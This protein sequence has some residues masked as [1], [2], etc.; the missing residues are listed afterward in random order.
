MRLSRKYGLPPGSLFHFMWRAINGERFLETCAI[1]KVF[2]DRIFRFFGVTDGG[3]QV[4]S[5]VM[6]SNHFHQAGRILDDHGP[7]SRWSRSA[8]SS[9]GLWLNKKL[10]R[11][12]PVAQDRPKIQVAEDQ[13][14]LKRIM[15]Y[16]DW[17][18][19]KAGMCAH[20]SEYRYSSY[21]FYA[22][23]ETNDWTR[24]LTPPTWY[25][26]SADTPENRQLRYR[27]DCDRYHQEGR[28]PDEDREGGPE[29]ESVHATGSVQFM[30]TR[31]ALLSRIGSLIRRKSMTP[32]GIEGYFRLALISS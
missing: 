18:P 11:R 27:Q 30:M 31:N 16:I 19:V 22:F 6:M 9:F 26:E 24:H 7:L 29:G 1:K 3:V 10:G 15:F 2:L 5:F 23:G 14:A 21:R 20:P 4:F 17:N 13:E 8:H 25:L 28:L 12:G 32:S